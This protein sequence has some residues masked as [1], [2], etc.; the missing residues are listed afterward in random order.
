MY[1]LNWTIH[2]NEAWTKNVKQKRDNNLTI[3]IHFHLFYFYFANDIF[4]S[5]WVP[6]TKT[7]FDFAREKKK[8]DDNEV[9]IFFFF[10]TI[11]IKFVHL[12]ENICQLCPQKW[13]NNW[14]IMLD[15]NDVRRQKL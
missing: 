9:G 8:S 14:E 15:F 6:G 1:G 7:H 13:L 2:F 4:H 5:P 12:T 10:S 3:V 11:Y